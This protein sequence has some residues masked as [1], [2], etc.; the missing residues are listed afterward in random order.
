MSE[1][2]SLEEEK[3]LGYLGDEF[4]LKLLSRIVYNT[5][6][7]EDII[8][9]LEPRY[10]E[11]I[12]L[13]RIFII[14]KDYFRKHQNIPNI[15]NIKQIIKI[16]TSQEI[17]QQQLIATTKRITGY[18]LQVEAGKHNNDYEHIEKTTGLFVKQQEYKKVTNIA[19]KKLSEGNLDNI[20]EITEL[21]KKVSDYGDK[22]DYGTDVFDEINNVL[23]E[24]T[25][26]RVPTGIKFI[27]EVA[28]GLAP[29]EFGLILAGSGVGKTTV[30]C[31]MANHA[32]MTGHNV[33]Q[34]I[35]DENSKDD[36]KK[37]HYTKWTG[38]SSKDFKSNKKI[39]IDKI[40]AF[41]EQNKATV[42]RLII[43]KFVS[44]GMTV[45][46]LKKW[47]TQYEKKHAMKF[48]VIFIDYMDELESHKERIYSQ[49]DGEL[50][51]AKAI[52]S[53]CVEFDIPI[54]SAVQGTKGSNIKRILDKNDVGG[55]IAKIKKAQLVISIGRDMEQ[56]K[57]NKANFAIIKSNFCKAGNIW[58]DCTLN[59]EMMVIDEGILSNEVVPDFDDYEEVKDE[60]PTKKMLLNETSSANLLNNIL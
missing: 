14:I 32:Y 8:D 16:E 49:W 34:I 40:N 17:E 47:V 51:V 7:S 24:N 25:K 29:G 12:N 33:L 53:A 50:H 27:D 45:P 31:S 2:E 46:K 39:V 5:T 11:D 55:A 54:W 15:D 9:V 44:E 19:I 59:N 56:E 4:Q 57:N 22:K 43:K 1:K 42:G 52:Q 10:F 23:D 13:K 35:F 60:Q 48:Q 21:F 37:K 26:K 28:I 58:E 18:K 41:K 38:I 30:L 36:I 3:T 6:F 20:E